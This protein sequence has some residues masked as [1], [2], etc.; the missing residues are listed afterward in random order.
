M[1]WTQGFAAIVSPG[2]GWQPLLRDR[3]R[4]HFQDHVR[5]ANTEAAEIGLGMPPSSYW[6]VLSGNPAFGRILIMSQPNPTVLRGCDGGATPFDTGG[7]WHNHIVAV[8]PFTTPAGKVA[9]FNSTSASHEDADDEAKDWILQHYSNSVDYVYGSPPDSLDRIDT[10]S[11]VNDSRA[12]T[13][14]VRLNSLDYD[15]HPVPPV[16]V[17]L[18]PEDSRHFS[19]WLQDDDQ[20]LSDNDYNEMV[21]WCMRNFRPDD[22]P[23]RVALEQMVAGAP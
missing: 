9:Y 19:V 21:D 18:T 14:E 5:T 1:W 12:W 17:V 2:M 13:W 20:V 7:L 15:H 23:F 16:I 6:F 8:P 11:G 3:L 10:T 4:A 22:D